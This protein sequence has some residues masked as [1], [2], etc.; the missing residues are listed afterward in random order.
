[1]EINPTQKIPLLDYIKQILPNS[2]TN[3]IKDL[4]QKDRL[5]IVKNYN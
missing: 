3:T 5:I 1:M 4:N 2:Q